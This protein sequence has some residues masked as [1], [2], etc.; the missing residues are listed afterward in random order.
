[1][2]RIVST[3][4]AKGYVP[5]GFVEEAM[6]VSSVITQ[7]K[8]AHPQWSGLGVEERVR[9]LTAVY[10]ECVSRSEE[11][12]SLITQEIGKPI[13]ESREEL[14]THV[15]DFSW[16]LSHVK[17]SIAD[18]LT[19]EDEHEIHTLVYEPHGVSVVITPWNYPFGMMI[20]GVVP[21]LLVGNVVVHKCSE[22][23]PLVSKVI[24]EIFSTHLPEGVFSAVYGGREVGES[25]VDSDVDLVWFTGS[26][27][28]G[29]QI[30]QR[31][32]PRFIK[33]VLEL[34][35]SNPCV[36]CDDVDVRV[37]AQI[38]FDAR[39]QVNGQDC[40]A[41]KRLI[42]HESLHDPLVDALREL[43]ESAKV[44]D[45]EDEGTLLGSLASKHQLD[46]IQNQVSDA[47]NQGATI[48]T[49]GTRPP[50]LDG[51]FFLPTVLTNVSTHMR[52][53]R[54]EVFGPALPVISFSSEEQAVALAN[55]TIYGLGARVLC[56]DHDRALRIASQIQA[57]GV[58]INSA[59]R[60]HPSNPFGGRKHSGVGV[61]HGVAGFRELC[62]RKV[63]S[64]PRN[65]DAEGS[66]FVLRQ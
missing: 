43:C 4:P 37:A 58:E 9:F 28:V 45:P 30:A 11:I 52:V 25:L 27:S 23:C 13:R 29:Q 36:V 21:N 46:T 55:D 41:V 49:G 12:A 20:W 15:K 14:Q 62:Q 60:W 65:R 59:S 18:E 50:H 34:G 24:A 32:A 3:N 16:F 66:T 44:G 19:H 5:L 22:E 61:E 53:W 10:D 39:F 2:K 40:D 31:C 8:H 63:L 56:R 42:V 7:A 33:T 57:G 54:E 1:M 17:Q 47:T 35:G 51:A 38:I 26:T 48:I 6:D 64:V